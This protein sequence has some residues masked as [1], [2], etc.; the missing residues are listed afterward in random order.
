MSGSA[1]V[2]SKAVFQ[3]RARA[4]G[5]TQA[6]ISD[7]ELKGW[8]TIATFAF[9]SGHVPGSRDETLFADQVLIPLLGAANH[10]HAP[11]LRRLFFECFT[12]L[13]AELKSKVEKGPEEGTRKLADPERRV[14][15]R[16]LESQVQGLVIVDQWEPAYSLTD[17]YVDMFE[18]NTLVYV[19]WDKCISRPTELLGGRKDSSWRAGAD[20]SVREVESITFAKAD[21]SSDFKLYQLLAR[22]GMAIH[23]A[24]MMTYAAHDK[25]VQSLIAEMHREQP[26]GWNKVS[27]D[28]LQRADIELWTRVSEATRDGLQRD[29][30][31][32]LPVEESFTRLMDSPQVRLM[33]LPTQGRMQPITVDKQNVSRQGHSQQQTQGAQAKS[34]QGK[35][36][37]SSSGQQAVGGVSKA[38]KRK[39]KQLNRT[40]KYGASKTPEGKDICYAF[41]GDGC[42]VSNCARE[43]VCQGCFGRHSKRQCPQL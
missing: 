14:R 33:L 43:H 17:V 26:A 7:M 6:V 41:N 34:G 38:Q 31:G 22:R 40:K 19:P 18:K 15:F 32:R 28:Q 2:D 29:A 13:S 36:Q 3:G 24:G 9:S 27:I 42:N 4:M 12:L 16:Q 30:R 8:S 11:L 35:P 1:F 5:I 21:Y 37:S 39:T 20:K 23:M 10:I 25:W